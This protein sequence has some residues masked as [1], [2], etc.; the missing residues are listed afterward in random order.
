M[1][2]VLAIMVAT[3][4]ISSK[5]ADGEMTFHS[6]TVGQV[7][8]LGD[9]ILGD[10]KDTPWRNIVPRKPIMQHGR[11]GQRPRP[12]VGTRPTYPVGQPQRVNLA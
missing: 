3:G 8:N 12:V 4:D 9:D 7:L 2:F 6:R 1:S 5:W 11:R 10:A